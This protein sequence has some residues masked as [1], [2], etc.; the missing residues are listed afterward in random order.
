MAALTNA[1]A[2]Q[3][4]VRQAAVILRKLKMRWR[5][6]W[7]VVRTEAKILV[8]PI[9]LDDFPGIHL[10]VWVPGC[11]ELVECLDEFRSEHL[12]QKFSTSLSIAVLAR[13]GS[14]VAHH[15]V[16]SFAHESPE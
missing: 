2:A 5:T 6:P 11:L 8:H 1:D 14:S 10:P 15:Q 12:G 9:R 3:R 7:M 16:G 4:G 13:E